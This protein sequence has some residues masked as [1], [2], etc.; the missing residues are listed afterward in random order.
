MNEQLR[1]LRIKWGFCPTCGLNLEN[2]IVAEHHKKGCPEVKC[3]DGK[4]GELM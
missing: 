4:V 1:E 2:N 3:D